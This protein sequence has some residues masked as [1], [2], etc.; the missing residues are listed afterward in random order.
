LYPLTKEKGE[1]TWTQDHQSAFETL[2]KALLQAQALT[3]P[4]LNKPFTLYIE[5]GNGIARGVLTQTL[6]PWKRPVA[7]L[8]K[9]LDPVASGWTSCLHAIAATVVMVKD[10]DKLTMGQN[11]TVVA[12]H[13]LES[14]IRKPPD[15][16]MTNT[17]MTHYQSLLLTERVTFAPP[18]I[19]NP[20]NLLPEIDKTPVH[21]CEEIL[22]LAEEMGTRPDL[23]DQP[24]LGAATWF[25]NG[26]SFMVEGKRRAGTAVLDGKS[27][28]WSSSLPEGTSAQKA[29]LIA[30]TQ[31][32][33][34]AEGKAIN[35]YRD[36]RYAFA[37]AHVHAA[38]YRQCGLLTSAGRDIENREEILSLLEAVHLPL[39]VAI[40][41][42]PGHQKG[43][44]PIERGNLMADQVAKEAAQGTMTLVI[45]KVLQMVKGRTEKRVLTEE[46]GLKYLADIHRLTH[47][48]AKKM[49]KLVSRSPY[50]IPGLQ[51]VTEGLVRNCRACTLTNAGSSRPKRR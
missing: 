25:T 13:S 10:A 49:I 15:R 12:P 39:K 3:M 11:I 43:T 21:N 46:E 50:H 4:D 45:K 17:P 8:S 18:T 2:K 7:Y 14:I 33:R 35:I 40:I 47:L 31:I 42:C 30:L 38:I 44:E 6:G 22:A 34:L 24:W 5:E 20:A 29:E 27:V 32:L 37:K 41:H 9:K 16:W 26:S 19:V 48:G 23:T 28:I 51:Q 36:S 1:F